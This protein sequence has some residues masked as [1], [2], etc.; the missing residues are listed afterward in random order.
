MEEI[1]SKIRP[2]KVNEHMK[3]SLKGPPLYYRVSV[4]SEFRHDSTTLVDA[5][6]DV[7][8]VFPN[9]RADLMNGEWHVFLESFEAVAGKLQGIPMFKV[10]LPDLIKSSQDYVMTDVGVCQINDAVEHVPIAQEYRAPGHGD[11]DVDA[12]ATKPIA[13][14]NVIGV[15]DIGVKVDPVA[16]FSGQLR[17]LL[18]SETHSVLEAGDENGKLGTAGD[19]WRG[20]FLF[21]HKP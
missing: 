12:L 19:G 18:R 5:T 3:Q 21:V 10:C 11:G 9:Q 1:K 8:H 4:V 20:T 7:N 2:Y 15:D 16:L 14:S 6:F 17:V 13:V